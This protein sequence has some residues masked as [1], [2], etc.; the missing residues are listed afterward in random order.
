VATSTSEIRDSAACRFS[1]WICR[2]WTVF[3]NRFWV[4]PS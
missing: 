4:A 1:A 2:F 3:C